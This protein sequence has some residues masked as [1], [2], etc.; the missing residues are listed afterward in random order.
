MG[1]TFTH[2]IQFRNNTETQTYK[3][4]RWWRTERGALRA[5]EKHAYGLDAYY[6]PH[7]IAQHALCIF[8][9]QG[10]FVMNEAA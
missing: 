10:R 3:S 7:S 1:F 6:A 4:P 9:D 5:A 8:D 2:Q